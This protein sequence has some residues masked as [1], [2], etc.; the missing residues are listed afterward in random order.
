MTKR[1]FLRKYHP[2]HYGNLKQASLDLFSD[3][4]DS[5]TNDEL[6][7]EEQIGASRYRISTMLEVYEPNLNDYQWLMSMM[8]DV[9]KIVS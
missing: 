1:E 7:L 6:P 3:I 8:A 5:F 4:E 9:Q 2:L